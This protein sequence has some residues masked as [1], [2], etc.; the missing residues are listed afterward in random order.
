[1]KILGSDLNVTRIAKKSIINKP[2]V[3]PS[4]TKPA[5]KIHAGTAHQDILIYAFVKVFRTEK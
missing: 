3:I 5:S 1:M 2:K 4:H